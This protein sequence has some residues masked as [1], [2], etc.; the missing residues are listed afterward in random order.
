ML[1]TQLGQSVHKRAQ[2][3][4]NGEVGS[5]PCC[6]PRTTPARGCRSCAGSPERLGTHTKLVPARSLLGHSFTSPWEATFPLP[7]LCSLRAGSFMCLL[8]HHRAG[9]EDG[10][11]SG[12]H[13]SGAG[14]TA[15]SPSCSVLGIRPTLWPQQQQVPGSGR[16]PPC[17][18]SGEGLGISSPELAAF[19]RRGRRQQAPADRDT[20]TRQ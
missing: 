18:R 4:L 10:H 1:R 8:L 5:S 19:V 16:V 9:P 15:L 12:M 3:K 13:R 14:G 11:T 17:Q 7:Q 2:D 6:S 20:R